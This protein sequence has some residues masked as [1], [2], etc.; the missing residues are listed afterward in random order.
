MKPVFGI[1]LHLPF[2]LSKCR[3]CDFNSYAGMQWLTPRYAAALK[4]EARIWAGSGVPRIDGQSVSTMYCGGGTPTVLGPDLLGDVIRGCRI[5]MGLSRLAEFTVEANPGTVTEADMDRLLDAGVNRLSLGVQS[6]DDSEL[7]LLGR[8]H[9]AEDARKAVLSAR[10][11]GFDNLS[12]DLMFGLPDQDLGAWRDSLEQAIGLNPEHLSLYALTLEEGTA[13]QLAVDRGEL[14]R[15]DP[16]MGAEMYS[17]AE[18]MLQCTGYEHYEISNWARPGK[19]CRHNLGYWHNEQYI[20]LGAGAH[21]YIHPYRTANL[22]SPLQYITRLEEAV[23][24]S[25]PVDSKE[26]IGRTMEMG[27]TMMLGL[28]L[29]RGV[30]LKEFRRRFGVELPDIYAPQIAETS[31][32]GLLAADDERLLLTPKGRLLGNEVFWRFLENRSDRGEP[33]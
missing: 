20:G 3:Y 31:R 24:G 8:V 18:E 2:C 32:L 17:L 9:G 10:R 12:L 22:R 30:S 6:F 27:E 21:S 1:Y 4:R 5:E 14:A 11:A 26:L 15:P 19:E 28:R 29:C 23:L 25:L 33:A 16:D 7:D 13:M